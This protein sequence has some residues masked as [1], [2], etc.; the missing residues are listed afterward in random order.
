MRTHLPGTHLPGTVIPGTHMPETQMLETHLPGTH[1]LGTHLPGT[2]MPETQMLETYLPGTHLPGTHLPGTLLPGTLLP[3]T[4]MPEN[5]ML[6]TYLQEPTYQEHIYQEPSYQEPTC[7][8]PSCQEPTTDLLFIGFETRTLEN[9]ISG[10]VNDK[11]KLLRRQQ[12]SH[13]KLTHNNTYASTKC[14]ELLTIHGQD[15]KWRK[16]RMHYRQEYIPVGYVRTAA[17][18]I[19]VGVGVSAHMWGCSLTCGGWLQRHPPDKQPPGQ[20][21][22]IPHPLSTTTLSPVNRMTHICESITFP[23]LAHNAVGKNMNHYIFCINNM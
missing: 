22:R 4:H 7:Q 12:V 19:S 6:E 20:T 9:R 18:A 13:Q 11:L 10:S 2:H 1:L 5:Q 14:K 15:S 3:G 23:A 17:V 21:L 16:T 8:E